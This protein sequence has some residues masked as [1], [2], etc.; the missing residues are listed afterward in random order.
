MLKKLTGVLLCLVLAFSVCPKTAF[1]AG[2][3]EITITPDQ[4]EVYPGDII[5]YTI[6]LG[7]V[8]RMQGFEF[9]IVVPDGLTY[10]EGSYRVT[11][12]LQTK[13]GSEKAEFTESSKIFIVYGGGCYTSA[14]PTQI[15]TFTCTATAV[16]DYTVKMINV[17][18]SDPEYE[19]IDWTPEEPSC[20][21]TVKEKPAA[22]SGVSLDKTTLSTK[23][24]LTE[25]LTA[26]VS[27]ANAGNQ[28]V[29][30]TSSDPSV[31]TVSAA[32]V[33]T[34]VKKGTATITVTTEEGGFTASCAVNVACSHTKTTEHPAESST[35]QKQGHEAYTI[36]DECGEII[37]GSDAELPLAAH[38]YA[39]VADAKYLKSAATCVSK[40]VYYESCT[41]CGE[42]GTKTF[43]YGTVDS[44]NH[45]G[46]TYVK[47]QKEATCYEEGYTGDQYCASCNAL[48]E[49]G[50][51]IEKE[52]HNPADV[53]SS[54]ETDH[55]KECQTVGC[56]NIIDKAAHSGGEAT[57]TQK[58]ICEVC[59]VAYGSVDASN[60]KHTEIRGAVE[61]TCTDGYTGDTYCK[62]CGE[63]LSTGKIIPAKH[64]LVKVE[65]KEAT[66]E[67][68]GN[69]EYYECS[70]CGKIFADAEATEEITLEDTI[71]P[72]GEHDY[73]DSY[74]FDEKNH[75][76]E[77][78]CGSIIE[79]A[80]HTFGDWNVVK[81]ATDTEK[82][83]QERTC[84]V[85]GYT[86]TEEIP[87]IEPTEEPTSEPVETEEPTT[88]PVETE[89]PTTAPVETEEPTS[90]PVETEEP[91]TAPVE[92]E[93]P[94]TEPVETE[95]PTTAPVETEEP[96]TEPVET[97][98]PTTA[99]VETEEPT[100]EPVE[101]EEPTTA[102]V[103]TEEPTTA[104][105]ETEEPTTAPAETE[106][107]ETKP[108]KTLGEDDAADT[109]DN[110][111]FVFWVGLLGVSAVGAAGLA[112]SYK[113][114]KENE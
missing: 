50:S 70:V 74:V 31:A 29:T 104:P 12:G 113:K 89:E 75:W 2:A 11:D 19:G 67:E 80:A 78:G 92:T 56:G 103:E 8:E 106:P 6:T 95:E 63:K 77:C 114:R 87:V 24:G 64:T 53:W 57:C 41:V 47:D 18:V 61:A 69:I 112:G 26:T 79:E 85:C 3:T 40:A 25:T 48:I 37:S 14:S 90:E 71:I 101:T 45:V 1:A 10:N 73:G 5:T 111:L 100:T 66:H 105:V 30:W 38:T 23:T 62:D 68:D 34:G 96:T 13:F 4:A 15:M 22:V 28:N 109:G 42:K 98:E 36:C 52:A 91:T 88:E 17:D 9:K 54:D 32:G 97:E 21:V 35:C 108:D 93:E 102:P 99:P 51:V 76:K 110:G 44:H 84:S 82:G 94:T 86:E 59:G 81:E 72:Q 107:T 27:P 46:G 43:E 39:Q 33:V 20:T 65:A 55:W 83:S 16:G 60:H 58:A 7:A 49:K